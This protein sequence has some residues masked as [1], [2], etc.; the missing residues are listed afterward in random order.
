MK[1][2]PTPFLSPTIRI[3]F[4][5]Q[6]RSGVLRGLL[7]LLFALAHGFGAVVTGAPL[8]KTAP[9]ITGQPTSLTVTEGSPASFQLTMSTSS[10]RPMTFTWTKSGVTVGTNS[11]NLYIS[12]VKASDAGSYSCK[13]SNGT[14]PDAVSN[15]VTITIKAGPANTPASA[16]G[17]TTPPPATP[18]PVTPAPPATPVTPPG[19]HA[20]QPGS[21]STGTTPAPPT[22]PS[23]PP[24]NV[25]GPTTPPPTT[26]PPTTPV[27]P[28]GVHAGQPGSPSTGTTPAPPTTPAT[29]AAPAAPTTRIDTLGEHFYTTGSE[30]AGAYRYIGIIGHLFTDPAPGRS[31]LHRILLANGDHFATT[32]TQEIN[33]AVAAGGRDEGTLGYVRDGDGSGSQIDHF[34]TMN[35]HEQSTLRMSYEGIACWLS[36]TSSYGT[37]AVYR[38]VDRQGMHLLTTSV[39]EKDNLIRAGWTNEGIPGYLY[40]QSGPANV[41]L[42]RIKM[43]N[44]MTSGDHFYTTS[45]IERASCLRVTGA[46][47]EGIIGYAPLGGI[48]LYRLVDGLHHFYT[49]SATERDGVVFHPGYSNEGVLGYAYRSQR[50]GTVPLYRLFGD[51]H[52]LL[53]INATERQLLLT[54]G[55]QDEGIAGWVWPTDSAGTLKVTVYRKYGNGEHLLTTNSNEAPSYALEGP[56][57]KLWSSEV[58]SGCSPL[59]RLS[60]Q[61]GIP[62]DQPQVMPLKRLQKSGAHV[63]TTS[64]EEIA[65]LTGQG[66]NVEGSAG[67]IATSALDGTRPLYRLDNGVF[68]FLSI[69]AT[70]RDAQV[71]V[72][73]ATREGMLGHVLTY[74][75]PGTLPLYRYLLRGGRHLWTASVDEVVSIV[76]GGATS[77]GVVGYVYPSKAT[78][79]GTVAVYRLYHPSGDHLY[80]TS[81]TE[82]T[83]AGGFTLEGEAFRLLVNE[84]ADTLPWYRLLLTWQVTVPVSTPVPGSTPTQGSSGTVISSADDSLFSPTGEGVISI[85]INTNGRTLSSGH[86]PGSR[87]VP[88]VNVDETK[89][90]AIISPVLTSAP[91]VTTRPVDG[92]VPG[93][94]TSRLAWNTV[95]NA[96]KYVVKVVDMN[97]RT[98]INPVLSSSTGTV[99]YKDILVQDGHLYTW[100]VAAQD[101]TGRLGPAESGEFTIMTAGYNSDFVSLSAYDAWAAVDEPKAWLHNYTALPTPGDSYWAECKATEKLLVAQAGYKTYVEPFTAKAP[102]GNSNVYWGNGTSDYSY[103]PGYVKD[104]HDRFFRQRFGSSA[105]QAVLIPMDMLD[106]DGKAVYQAWLDKT[107]GGNLVDRFMPIETSMDAIAKLPDHGAF[108]TD[109]AVVVKSFNQI[110]GLTPW[111]QAAIQREAVLTDIYALLELEGQALQRQFPPSVL[112]IFPSLQFNPP[113]E[114]SLMGAICHLANICDYNGSNG[115]GSFKT[116]SKTLIPFTFRGVGYRLS[117]DTT[118]RTY[119]ASTGISTSF[120]NTLSLQDFL[121]A[122]VAVKVG[123]P[124]FTIYVSKGISIKG[125]LDAAALFVGANGQPGL[126]SK[127]TALSTAVPDS[128]NFTIQD[129][130]AINFGYNPQTRQPY[131]RINTYFGAGTPATLPGALGFNGKW[132]KSWKIDGDLKQLKRPLW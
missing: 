51:H 58:D 122:G 61:V 14:L 3:F 28:P 85:P 12:K 39:V 82:G 54:L 37:V 101:S 66:W 131:V 130:A 65:V 21:P 86:G 17:P 90:V 107:A 50:S 49:A 33:Q 53:T 63:Y 64:S 117:F 109:N 113:S 103:R 129:G 11:A 76:A 44:G 73:G 59:Y 93:G 34:Y 91:T 70:E 25:T 24:A 83:G 13:V 108:I 123:D 94:S 27:T 74:Q 10:S 19:V 132:G 45:A 118:E 79:A 96:S 15:T 71:T 68:S 88:L 124:E 47:D 75:A 106:Q 110:M 105:Y 43:P 26:P 55:F 62:P 31:A 116:L 128:L 72:A 48:P 60:G 95:A 7:I 8:P 112:A 104:I 2:Q 78:V 52:H 89:G 99:T 100:S 5:I 30:A 40:T 56:A 97:L 57:F 18:P 23:T 127:L 42:Y 115:L 67:F 20:G 9:K 35:S 41:A 80:S 87:E 1:P 69:S 120:S 4:G 32:S 22:T 114:N 38:L 81:S 29:P 92:N 36:A 6:H 102:Y 121:T 84:R 46:V 16:T 98:G 77:E 111:N 126:A 125:I 119:G